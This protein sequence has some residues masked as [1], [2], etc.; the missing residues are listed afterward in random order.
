MLRVEAL[1]NKEWELINKRPVTKFTK[2]PKDS[3]QPNP[4]S[5]KD[6]YQWVCQLYLRL[7]LLNMATSTDQPSLGM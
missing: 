2:I 7:Y 1:I 3:I 6:R 4:R 5:Y